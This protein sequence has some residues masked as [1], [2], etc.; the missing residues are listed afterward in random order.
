V[1]LSLVLCVIGVKMLLGA[2]DVDIPT[3]I[4]LAVVASIILTSIVFSVIV[5]R[6][7]QSASRKSGK[8]DGEA[9]SP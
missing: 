3:S 8:Q 4:S 6:R 9:E 7:D 2:V 1:G 5:M